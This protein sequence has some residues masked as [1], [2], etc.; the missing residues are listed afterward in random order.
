[1]IDGFKPVLGTGWADESAGALLSANTHSNEQKLMN[2][3]YIHAK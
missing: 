2:S 3:G 1:M